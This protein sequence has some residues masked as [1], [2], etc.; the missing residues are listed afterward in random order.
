LIYFL[1]DAYKIVTANAQM[2][3][4]AMTVT[5]SSSVFKS[6][7]WTHFNAVKTKNNYRKNMHQVTNVEH[8]I[9]KLFII[10][11]IIL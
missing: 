8:D 11:F 4:Q 9:Q 6:V 7:S 1:K 2:A 3:C 5:T 10:I